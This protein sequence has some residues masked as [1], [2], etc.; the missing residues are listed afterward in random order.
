M[1]IDREFVTIFIAPA[2]TDGSAL[3]TSDEVNG[4]ITSHNLTGGNMDVESVPAFGG[5]IDKRKPREQFEIQ[6]DVTPKFTTTAAETDR[7]DIFKYGT[8]GKS[9]GESGNYSIYIEAYDSLT[10][11]RKTTAL[12]NCNMTNWEPA[13]SADDNM[14]GSATFK[15]SPETDSGAANLATS[16]L[17]SSNG[18]FNWT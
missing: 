18:F 17:G 9:T 10:G 16:A 6:M 1:A 8:T 4:E 5:F 7:W 12:N 2:D 3:A 13:H 15:F 11:A 14:G